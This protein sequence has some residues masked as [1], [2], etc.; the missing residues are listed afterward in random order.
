[1]IMFCLAATES[2][3]AQPLVSRTEE[4]LCANAWPL[5][6]SDGLDAYGAALFERHHVIE[7][8]P[9]T[10]KRGRP[11]RPK[12]VARPTLRYGQ[13]V[14]KRDEKRYVVGVF[15]RAVF[16]D[17]PLQRINTV[18]IE[19]HNLS[20]RHE[21]RRLTRKTLA[22]SKDALWLERQMHLYQAYFNFVRPHGGLAQRISGNG[23]HRW[24]R[25]TPAMAAGLADHMWS[26]RELMCCKCYYQ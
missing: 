19:R 11:R 10:G 14:K 25:R 16:G 12:M 21:N 9:R 6:V 3:L 26:L 22:F 20:L 18:C 5:W 8:Y 23:T 15:K 7:T 13:V 2:S 17:V 4:R 1:M 24:F